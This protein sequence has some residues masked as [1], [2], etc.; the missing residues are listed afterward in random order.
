[1]TATSFVDSAHEAR[2]RKQLFRSRETDR[3]PNRPS[4]GTFLATTTSVEVSLNFTGSYP[5]LTRLIRILMGSL[6]PAK[7]KWATEATK[8]R[9]SYYVTLWAHHVF[10]VL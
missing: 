2:R 7:S 4:S 8:Q 5:R 10:C 3:Q 1:L 9:E 6:P